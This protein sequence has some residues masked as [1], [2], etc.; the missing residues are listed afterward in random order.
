MPDTISATK[1][2]SAVRR[3]Q[4]CAG[5]RVYGHETKCKHIHGHNFQV[6][7]HARSA[8]GLDA[9]GRVIDFGVLKER[10]GTWIDEN[11]DHGVILWSKDHEAI[12]ALSKLPEQKMYLLSENP[13]AENL[14]AVLLTDIAPKLL[15][16]SGV[17]VEK[18]VLWET[19]NCF[20]EVELYEGAKS[21]QTAAVEC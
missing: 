2:I 13:T 7:F 21:R 20:A 4:F 18:V 14:A 15:A 10:L 6:F 11:W 12:E 5:H 16:D 17:V 3:I 8:Q 19:E 1:P 9:L